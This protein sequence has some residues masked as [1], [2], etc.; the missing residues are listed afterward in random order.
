MCNQ[1]GVSK[2][3]FCYFKKYLGGITMKAYV[4]VRLSNF[5]HLFWIENGCY[6][7]LRGLH[8]T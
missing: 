5:V 6:E 8:G 2:S 1:A 4:H 7:S 3:V